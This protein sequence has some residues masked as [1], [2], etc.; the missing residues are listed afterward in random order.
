MT[1]K[2]GQSTWWLQM[3]NVFLSAGVCLG[4]HAYLPTWGI[5]IYLGRWKQAELPGLRGITAS[6][7]VPN[8]EN[9]FFKSSVLDY[10]KK[11]QLFNYV[12]KPLHH[13]L[14]VWRDGLQCVILLRFVYSAVVLIYYSHVLN[15]VSCYIVLVESC[16]DALHWWLSTSCL[17]KSN[18]LQFA[19][20]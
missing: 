2:L 18:A 14:Q 17:C 16:C 19:W 20:I 12:V 11:T 10:R 7:T 6:V 3:T 5:R 8:G 4:K 9:A 1:G 15:K 13:E